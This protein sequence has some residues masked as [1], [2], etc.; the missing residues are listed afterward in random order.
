MKVMAVITACSIEV[1]GKLKHFI[2]F[3]FKQ[4]PASS[5]IVGLNSFYLDNSKIDFY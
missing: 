1:K 4:H 2:T 3:T 5:S